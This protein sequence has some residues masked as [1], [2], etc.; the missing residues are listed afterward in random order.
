MKRKR[1]RKSSDAIGMQSARARLPPA[2]ESQPE[3]VTATKGKGYDIN[4][5]ACGAL[6]IAAPVARK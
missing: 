4:G 3:G 1:K 6:I 2:Q 5:S